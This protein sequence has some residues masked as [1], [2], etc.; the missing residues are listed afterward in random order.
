MHPH[1][2]P[3]ITPTNFLMTTTN[4]DEY[5]TGSST[6]PPKMRTSRGPIW[7]SSVFQEDYINDDEIFNAF[8][9]A[10]SLQSF[11][12]NRRCDEELFDYKR[13]PFR[14]W[15]RRALLK[16][17]DEEV[18]R[19]LVATMET[20]YRKKLLGVYVGDVVVDVDLREDSVTWPEDQA[21]SDEVNEEVKATT[22]NYE[23][24]VDEDSIST[25]IDQ[26]LDVNVKDWPTTPTDPVIKK[27]DIK[28]STSKKSNSFSLKKLRAAISGIMW[29]SRQKR[30]GM[31]AGQVFRQP[32][33][34]A[35]R[36][37]EQK[38]CKFDGFLARAKTF[39]AK[40]RLRKGEGQGRGK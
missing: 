38:E 30:T 9:K 27:V 14:R 26:T 31:K 10:T 18:D 13:V 35:T 6:N 15:Q 25:P 17:R 34:D 4:Y 33:I 36:P 1:P 5:G 32:R 22:V 28:G 40:F 23:A 21:L 20:V 16:D 37:S 7:N 11:R 24:I 19:D 8:V 39:F 29:T 3:S 12:D 2:A